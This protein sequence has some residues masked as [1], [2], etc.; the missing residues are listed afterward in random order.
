MQTK[1]CKKVQKAKQRFS[2][3]PIDS[4]IPPLSTSENLNLKLFS[5]AAQADLCQTW[6]KTSLHI[7]AFR[8]QLLVSHSNEVS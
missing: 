3:H 7:I 5:V 6:L 2:F 1:R 4:T 8:R